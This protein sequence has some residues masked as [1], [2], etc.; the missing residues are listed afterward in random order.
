MAKSIYDGTI[1]DNRYWYPPSL[2]WE[3]IDETRA[4]GS[5][6]A[7]PRDLAWTPLI[8]AAF[9][10]YRHFFEALVSRPLAKWIL[11]EHIKK[12]VFLRN[13]TLEKLYLKSKVFAEVEHLLPEQYSARQGS[14]WFRSRNMH[15]N[16]TQALLKKFSETFYRCFTYTC[17]WGYGAYVLSDKVWLRE[18]KQAFV[19]FPMQDMTMDVL[20][21]YLL[22]LSFYCSL[23]WSLLKDHRRK[24]F[25]EHCIHHAA[26]VWLIVFSYTCNYIRIGTLVMF[27]HDVSD[28]LLESAKCFNYAKNEQGANLIF[29]AFVVVFIGTRNYLYPKMV[30]YT[31]LYDIYA[32]DGFEGYPIY[33]G[34]IG[35]L[36]VLQILNIFWTWSIFRMVYRLFFCPEMLM[37]IRS[38][39]EES[40]DEDARKE[41]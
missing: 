30:L 32:I 8:T 4:N 38:D 21:Y 26:T 41:K 40:G 29:G 3:A 20:V 5:N 1:W 22:E 27:L 10:L 2:S 7:R 39:S 33:Y 28:I 37:D 19:G 24:D 23:L 12:A 15:E 34:F 36:F 35:F 18:P 16:K 14:G 11:R 6:L 13:S 9:L 25:L 17:L 31:S